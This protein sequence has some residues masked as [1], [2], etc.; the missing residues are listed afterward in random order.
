[1]DLLDNLVEEKFGAAAAHALCREPG[2]FEPGKLYRRVEISDTLR[3]EFVRR[4][5]DRATRSQDVA[6]VLKKWLFGAASPFRREARGR[7]RFLGCEPA[8]EQA[9]IA[10]GRFDAVSKAAAYGPPTGHA[11]FQQFQRDSTRDGSAY[12]APTSAHAGGDVQIKDAP[13]HAAPVPE[14]ERALGQGNCE[15]YAWCLPRYGETADAR[16]PVNI[17]RAG[18][19]G[20]ARRIRDFQEH[21]PERPR[22]LL[23]LACADEGE[24][25]DREM[26]LHAWFTSRDQALAGAPG[27]GWFRTNPRELESAVRNLIDVGSVS[28]ETGAAGVE[29]LIAATFDGVTADDWATLPDDLTDRLDEHLYGV[30]PG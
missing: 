13:A 19:G 23:R 25:R 8:P 29:D 16:W 24:A 3:D 26:L 10:E 4:G 20:F 21:L 5:G 2:L 14:P 18:P 27:R 11:R 9:V 30:G 1:M 12:V 17:G 7:Y 6:T 28:G 22:Y 15:V